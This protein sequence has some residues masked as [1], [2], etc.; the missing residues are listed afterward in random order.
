MITKMSTSAWKVLANDTRL[1][2][3]G[4]LQEK[5]YTTS[6]LC[7]F[8]D[9]SRFG[10]MQHLK[11]LEAAGLIQVE[12]RGRYRL[13]HLNKERLAALYAEMSPG[14]QSLTAAVPDP[15]L[16]RIERAHITET[17]VYN[18]TPSILFTALTDRIGAWWHDADTPVILE[19]WLGGRFMEM[20]DEAQNGVLFATVDRFVRNEQ[21]GL[22]GTMGD[23]TTIS[24]LR[25]RITAVSNTQTML[26]LHHRFIGEVEITIYEAFK[27]SWNELLQVRLKDFLS[28]VP[29]HKL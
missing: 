22:F 24:L 2:L 25:L 26:T 5:A 14:G 3:I 28:K 29:D 4:L 12:R 21:L 16:L 27:Q 17:A 19:P 10:V 23:D 18:T 13:N 7:T 6:E 9:L 15:P 8:F 20:F 11:V 1:K